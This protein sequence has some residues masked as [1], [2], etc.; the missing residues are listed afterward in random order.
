[1]RKGGDAAMRTIRIT[2]VLVLVALLGTG[3]GRAQA[4]DAPAQLKGVTVERQVRQKETGKA[5]EHL[6]RRSAPA[7][8]S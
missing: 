4:A 2:S 3:V 8:G 6:G 1:M 7:C 5:V